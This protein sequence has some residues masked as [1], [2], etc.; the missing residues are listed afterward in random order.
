[1]IEL[2][3]V[4]KMG[5]RFYRKVKFDGWTERQRQELLDL[6]KKCGYVPPAVERKIEANKNNFSEKT[7]KEIGNNW[8]D[9]LWNEA[10]KFFPED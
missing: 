10:L 8:N 4:A 1:M 2:V 3:D 7:V 6:L 5:I 9:Y